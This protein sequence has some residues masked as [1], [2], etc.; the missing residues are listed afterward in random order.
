MEDSSWRVEEKSTLKTRGRGRNRTEKYSWRVE[1][2]EYV[3]LLQLH[4]TNDPYAQFVAG[5][6]LCVCCCRGN[7]FLSSVCTYCIVDH[8]E[9]NRKEPL[10]TWSWECRG[11]NGPR[12]SLK[13]PL[14]SSWLMTHWAVMAPRALHIHSL[15][16]SSNA[17]GEKP[18]QCRAVEIPKKPRSRRAGIQTLIK[19]DAASIAIQLCNATGSWW[20]ETQRGWEG[21]EWSTQGS[22]YLYG[23]KGWFH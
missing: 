21:A 6:C 10:H 17:P 12:S 4:E 2:V 11:C 14:I 19:K 5:V 9:G 16:S 7:D 1:K 23:N 13:L 15:C 18:Q 20:T 8:K 3:P 22:I